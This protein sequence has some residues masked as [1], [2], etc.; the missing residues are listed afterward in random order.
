MVQPMKEEICPCCGG[1]LRTWDFTMTKEFYQHICVIAPDYETAVR[2]VLDKA[3][4]CYEEEKIKA[5]T[6]WNASNIMIYNSYGDQ[7]G[8]VEKEL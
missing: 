2:K 7:C 1:K 6:S 4:V 5:P 8:E 3:A